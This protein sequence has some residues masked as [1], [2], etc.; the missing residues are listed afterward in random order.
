MRKA[1]L[2]SLFGSG[3]V[4][5]NMGGEG[6]LTLEDVPNAYLVQETLHDLMEANG[7][8]RPDAPIG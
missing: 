3:N 1:G 5:V 8:P 6:R 7:A 2:Q 4:L